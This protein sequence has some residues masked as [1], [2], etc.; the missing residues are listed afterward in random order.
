M[1][2]WP[3]HICEQ[4]KKVATGMEKKCYKQD[5]RQKIKQ[6]ENIKAADRDED[7]NH[8]SESLLLIEFYMLGIRRRREN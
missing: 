7:T 8:F 5:K 3:A 1:S 4:K 6:G 2:L